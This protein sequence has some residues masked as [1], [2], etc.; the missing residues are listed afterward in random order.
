MMN[1]INF[2][3]HMVGRHMAAITAE[4][5]LSP[6]EHGHDWMAAFDK[7]VVLGARAKEFYEGLPLDAQVE[8]EI[9]IEAANEACQKVNDD[10]WTAWFRQFQ[11]VIQS[12]VAA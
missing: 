8:I 5:S 6:A 11:R 12:A 4:E 7:A 3:V 2:Y 1:L 10:Y 9:A